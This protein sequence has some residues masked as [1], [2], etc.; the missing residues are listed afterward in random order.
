LRDYDRRRDQ[1]CPTPSTPAFFVSTCRTRLDERNIPNTFVG[2]IDA[3]G[4]T[5]PPGRR[6]TPTTTEPATRGAIRHPS[7]VQPV[8]QRPERVAAGSAAHA[9]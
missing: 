5:V 3:A 7:H 4:I 8:P 1:W 9:A 6:S 2:L